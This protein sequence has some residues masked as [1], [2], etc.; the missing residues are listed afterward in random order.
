MLLSLTVVVVKLN[1][2][3]VIYVLSV[4]KAEGPV[5][6][7]AFGISVP[8]LTHCP[9][10]TT[11]TTRLPLGSIIIIMDHTALIPTKV[12]GISTYSYYLSHN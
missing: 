4:N 10:E 6:G 2:N 12:L 1:R 9:T 5:L 3:Q 8:K 7:Q 11:L